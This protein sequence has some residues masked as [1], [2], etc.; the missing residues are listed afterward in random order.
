MRKALCVS[1][2][3]IC[4]QAAAQESQAPAES[5][6]APANHT[7]AAGTRVPLLLINSISTRSAHEGDQVYLETA[8]PIVVNQKI[9]IPRG[10]YVKGT[11]TQVKRP[12]RV[13][14]RGEMYLR[15]DSLTL[16]NGVTRDFRGRVGAVDGSGNETLEKREGKI[17][18]EAA[19]GQ[20]AGTVASTAGAGT[21]VGAIAGSASKHPGL[22]TGIGAMGGA[23][24]GVAQVLLTRGPDV[25]LMRGTELDMVL[26][27]TLAFT[28]DELRFESAPPAGSAIPPPSRT[29][30]KTSSQSGIPLPRRMPIP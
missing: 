2:L 22:G 25:Q 1:V 23:A 24:A 17:V 30:S 5:Q 21:A 4:L 26:D 3:A 20:D 19:K 28:E 9:V 12:G 29:N 11:I 14:G 7:V 6:S 16:P 13:K 18:S 10:S 8:F 15:F 27:R